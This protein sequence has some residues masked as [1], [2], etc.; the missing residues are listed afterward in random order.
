MIVLS[1]KIARYV[2]QDNPAPL[3]DD[4]GTTPL[5]T[6]ARSL[7][8]YNRADNESLAGH[9]QAKAVAGSFGC[10]PEAVPEGFED[11]GL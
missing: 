3:V 2:S 5:S 7:V 4:N 9:L 1:R 8:V 10:D 11:L 6:I